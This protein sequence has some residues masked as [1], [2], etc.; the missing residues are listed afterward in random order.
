MC[1]C[2]CECVCACVRVRACVCVRV[3][4]FAC[5]WALSLSLSLSRRHL[6]TLTQTSPTLPKPSPG[7]Y[8]YCNLPGLEFTQGLPTR[9]YMFALGGSGDMH[10]PNTAEGGLY[11][12]GQRRQG[13]RL[14]PGTML[15][16]DIT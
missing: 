10:T 4:A 1:A 14:L 8:L 12:D 6:V 5:G 16:A 11:L 2:E 13:V 7:S 15:A 9:L 3:C